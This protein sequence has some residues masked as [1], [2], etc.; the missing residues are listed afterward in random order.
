MQVICPECGKIGLL[1][2]ITPRY[3][4]VRHNIVNE[5][6]GSFKVTI[7]IYTFQYHRVSTE[8]AE[9][10]I[11]AEKQKEEAYLR[12]MINNTLTTSQTR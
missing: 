5:R 2:K 11:N 12:D 1:Q 7:R 3:Y 8:W 4:R 9:Q 6:A 10:Q